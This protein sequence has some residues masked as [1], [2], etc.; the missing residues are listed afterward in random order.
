MTVP[1]NEVTDLRA[2]RD[3]ERALGLDPQGSTNWD[4]LLGRIVGNRVALT[5]AM[6]KWTEAREEIAWRERSLRRLRTALRATGVSKDVVAAIE[7]DVEP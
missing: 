1:D 2:I 4:E 7:W 6:A 3:V 5:D